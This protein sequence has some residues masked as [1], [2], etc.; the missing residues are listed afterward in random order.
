[1]T[2]R[3]IVLF[4]AWTIPAAALIL[5]LQPNR[6]VRAGGR[7][8]P[9]GTS[10]SINSPLGLPPVPDPPDNPPTAE[11]IALGRRLFYDPRL[12]V[13]NTVSCS[14]CHNPTLAFSDG[15]RVAEGVKQQKGLRNAPSLLNAAYREGR[16]GFFWD[17]PSPS[18]EAQAQEPVKNS[19]E[20]AH[21]LEGVEH[22]LTAD[23][24]YRA[25]FQRAFGDGP[26]TYDEVGKAMAS[27]ERTLLCGNSPF[28]RYFYGHDESALSESAKRGFEIFRNPGEANCATCHTIGDQY[29]LFTDNKF[30]N[31]S[32]GPTAQN[33]DPIDLGRFAITRVDLDKGAFRTPSLRNVALTAPYFHDGSRA[34]L[35][36]VVNFYARGG[37]PVRYR[38][39]ELQPL[40]LTGEDRAD[41]VTFL[42]S[43]TGEMPANAGPPGKK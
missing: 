42:K 5:L 38:D 37:N 36:E 34:T 18:L 15:K 29:A 8:V 9:T 13:D 33:D 14:T 41:L 19:L 39:K 32:V 16:E 27:F 3:S 28:D 30:H 11:T 4:A 6:V 40:W 22:K 20:M 35:E 17:G 24:G 12:S 7:A 1:M 26:I 43:L 25:A 2:S 10:I 21:S 23:P 31:D